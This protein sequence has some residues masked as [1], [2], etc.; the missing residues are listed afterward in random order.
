MTIVPDARALA[1]DGEW[2]AHRYDPQADAVHFLHLTR[3][4]HRKATFLTD[5]YLPADLPRIV[6]KRQP[7]VDQLEPVKGPH[8][9][10]HSA[11]CCSTVLARAFD[12][13]GVARGLKEPPVFNDI[14]GW[15]HRGGGPPA[16]IAQVIDHA[17]MLLTRPLSP[18]ETA[19]IKP[20]NLANGLARG[21]LAMRGGTNALL[22]YAP[23]EIYLRSIAKKEMT[24]RLW[25]RDLLGKLLKEGLIDLGFTTE[26]YLGLTDL[27]V[28]AVG[29][30]AQHA[31]F[32]R[33]AHEFGPDRVRTLD[34]ETLLARPVEVVG[35]LSQLYGLNL[36][37]PQVSSIVE[38]PA[39]T[40]H[41]KHAGSF[42][43]QTRAAEYT[44]AALLHEDELRK[45][46]IWAEAVATAAELSM[47]L[48]DPLIGN[49]RP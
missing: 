48:P 9:I 38:G 49:A 10:F 32:T 30:L 42:G 33:L 37:I 16:R 13:P 21:I 43:A 26:D 27:Q 6:A 47:T 23:L 14:V 41:S 20:S 5:E 25:V 17:T 45:V 22:L 44:Q 19:I 11:F 40:T 3:E 4:A 29:W 31:L 2:F 7:V 8:F 24:G 18:G 28:A 34:S 12:I 39:F 1:Q 36:S 46:G 35:A 15:R